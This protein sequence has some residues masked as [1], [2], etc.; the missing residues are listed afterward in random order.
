MAAVSQITNRGELLDAVADFVDRTDLDTVIQS[1]PALVEAELHRKVVDGEPLRHWRMLATDNLT[2]SNGTALVALP[3]AAS[4]TGDW[5]ETVSL[6]WDTYH[7]KYTSPDLLD[8]MKRTYENGTE[9]SLT[10]TDPVY[11]YRGAYFELWPTP[12]ADGILYCEY[13]HKIP[14]MTGEGTTNWLLTGYPDIY[15]YG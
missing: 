4:N 3:T 13:Y 2:I 1:L 6:R 11:T 7:V 15:L 14:A 12:T 8:I 9:P 5:L 10:S